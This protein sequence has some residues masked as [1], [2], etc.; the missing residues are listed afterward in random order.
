MRITIVLLLF[1]FITINL[2]SC[3]DNSVQPA[4]SSDSTIA[5]ADSLWTYLGLGDQSIISIGLDPVNPKVIYA[6]SGFNFNSG[7]PGML[8]KSTDGGNRWDTLAAANDAQFMAVIVDPRN[9][10]TVYAAP[11]GIIK[12]SDGGVTW[13][14]QDNGVVTFPGE[15]HVESLVMDPSNSNIL[16]AGTGG[17]FGGNLYKTTNAGASWSKIGADSMEGGGVISIAIDS[18]NTGVIYAGTQFGTLWKSTDAGIGWSRTGLGETSIQGMIYAVHID[19]DDQRRIYGVSSW[20]PSGYLP[21]ATLHG[22][23]ESSDAGTTWRN[24]NKGL[25]D[26]CGVSRIAQLT[27]TGTLYVPVWSNYGAS[28]IY[29]RQKEGNSWTRIGLDAGADSYIYCDLKIS[30]DGK[31]LYFGSKGIFRLRIQ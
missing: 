26:S 19:C 27:S 8:F 1:L 4:T 23:F 12:S 29:E 30:V 22:V 6:G 24:Y 3:S 2:S 21:Q 15:T 11:S 20:A 7:I 14:A 10:T 18:R 17:A 25:P 9:A 31:F 13:Q 5:I 16:Y 28:G